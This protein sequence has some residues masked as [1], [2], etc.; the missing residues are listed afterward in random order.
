MSVMKCKQQMSDRSSRYQL[1]KDDSQFR[2]FKQSSGVRLRSRNVSIGGMAV[3][4]HL[5]LLLLACS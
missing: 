3:W 1:R 4:F 5:S 2:V